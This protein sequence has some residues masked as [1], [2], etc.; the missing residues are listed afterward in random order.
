[1]SEKEATA[2]T[3]TASTATA[4]TATT[5]STRRAAAS[6]AT[7][8]A[9]TATEAAG[10][11]GEMNNGTKNVALQEKVRKILQPSSSTRLFTKSGSKFFCKVQIMREGKPQKGFSAIR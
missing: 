9:T 10:A 5:P 7:E 3:R 6:T 4:A 2:A 1:M 11:D 8:A